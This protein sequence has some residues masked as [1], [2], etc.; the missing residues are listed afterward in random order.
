MDIEITNIIFPTEENVIFNH[1]QNEKYVKG[2]ITLYQSSQME[3]SRSSGLTPEVGSSRERDLIASFVSNLELNVNY[4]ITNDK[5]EDVIINDLK[6]SI[7]HSSNKSKSQ[8]GIKIIWTVDSEKRNEFLKNFTF[9]CDIII[10]YVRFSEILDKGELEIIFIRKEKLSEIH[11]NFKLSEKNVFK[12]LDGNS[13]GIEFDKKFFEEILKNIDFH[14]K[15]K[16]TNI[17]CDVCNPISKRV[18]LLN[19]LY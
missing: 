17:N 1:F 14:I 18:K 19:L 10:V 8:S 3:C 9:N 6:L 7:K 2:L 15:I 11:N 5:E 4:N 16:F 13:R 12:C